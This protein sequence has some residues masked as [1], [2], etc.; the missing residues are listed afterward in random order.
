MTFTDAPADQRIFTETDPQERVWMAFP[1][2]GSSI[3]QTQADAE[4]AR[5]AWASVAHAI[6]PFQPVVMAVDPADAAT[7]RRILSSEIELFETPLDD[8]WTRDTGPT[9]VRGRNG[10]LDAVNWTFNGWGAQDWARWDHDRHLATTIAARAGAP[11]IGSPLVNEGG[12]M[13]YDGLDTVFLTETVQLDPGRNP[14][15]DREAVER[16]LRRTLGVENYLWLPRGLTRDM[17]RYGTRGHADMMLACPAPG[18]LLVHIQNDPRHPDHAITREV[19]ALLGG[20]RWE[21]T[22]LP[23]PEVLEDEDGWV[24]FNYVNHVAING[25]V[26]ACAFDDPGDARAREILAG[27]YPGREVVTVDARPIFA[28]GGGIHCITLQEPRPTTRERE[29]NR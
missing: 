27:A 20:G 12:G 25:A 4:E 8:A 21:I 10:Q 13:V 23:A 14:H 24:D 19:M 11:S 9:F 1:P 22:A 28:R 26:I 18:R 7:A 3:A 6:L 17:Q 15:L 2:T 29:D 5:R 16:E